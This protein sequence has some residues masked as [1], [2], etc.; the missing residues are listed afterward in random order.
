MTSAYNLKKI[1]QIR[2]RISS[3]FSRFEDVLKSCINETPDIQIYLNNL[4]QEQNLLKLS[5]PSDI[6]FVQ[7]FAKQIYKPYTKCEYLIKIGYNVVNQNLPAHI[8]ISIIDDFIF[9]TCEI[10]RNEKN[11]KH[12]VLL[13]ASELIKMENN[14]SKSE[15]KS[16]KTS[17]SKKL[18]NII[19]YI[20]DNLRMN[21]PS[22]ED[23]ATYMSNH[24]ND[25][26]DKIYIMIKKV[27]DNAFPNIMNS[28]DRV[29]FMFGYPKKDKENNEI[30]KS[31]LNDSVNNTKNIRKKVKN[32]HKIIRQNLPQTSFMTTLLKKL[33]KFLYNLSQSVDNERID[34]LIDEMKQI[35]F[36]DEVKNSLDDIVKF[37][38]SNSSKMTCK[39]KDIL[40]NIFQSIY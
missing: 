12:A 38:Y 13:Q 33:R 22:D 1:N 8:N 19:L 2:R 35:I 16:E 25:Y 32:V 10:A 20:Y 7:L 15:L 14:M 5:L 4:K 34:I 6:H 39:E 23:A 21:K 37:I 36:N 9:K 27:P 24:V 11:Y 31:I 26:F 3:L 29:K 17:V 30:K 18:K 40:S 28:Y